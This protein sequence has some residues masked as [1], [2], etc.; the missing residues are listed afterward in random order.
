MGN[1]HKRKHVRNMMVRMNEI[2]TFMT[3]N[4]RQQFTK[5]FMLSKLNYGA[6]FL[7]GESTNV[8]R[9]YHSTVLSVARWIRSNYCFM[10]SVPKICRS[11]NIEI[12]LQQILKEAAKFCHSVHFHRRPTHIISQIRFPGTRNIEKLSLKYKKYD[13]NLISESISIH[14]IIP[15]HLK[16]LPLRKFSKAVRKIWIIHP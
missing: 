6:K 1:K 14:N 3:K 15:G 13:E 12:P 11:V 8:R 7:A 9:K 2:K 16:Q 10:E 5:S 4:K